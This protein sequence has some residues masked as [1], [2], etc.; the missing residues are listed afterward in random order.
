MKRLLIAALLLVATSASAQ[1]SETVNVEVIQVP[2]YV[3]GPDGAPI[4]GLKRNQFELYIDGY[5]KPFDYFDAV[6]VTAPTDEPRSQK[7]R[8]LYLLLFDLSC[9]QTDCAGLPGRVARAQRAAGKAIARSQLDTDLFA[10]ATYRTNHGVQFATPFLRD[11][12]AIQRAVNTLSSSSAADPLGLAISNAERLVW[13]KNTAVDNTEQAEIAM[14]TRNDEISR[15]IASI[16][17]G[18]VANQDNVREPLK[19]VI[20]DEFTE[21]AR[22]AGRLAKLEGQKHVI[23]FSQGFDANTVL[24]DAQ[25]D[26][27]GLKERWGPDGRRMTYMRKMFEAFQAAGVFLNTVDINGLRLDPKG[28]P[29]D[30]LQMLAS[31]T[32]GEFVKNRN[33][34]SVAVTDLTKRQEVAYLLGFDRRNLATGQIEIKVRGIPRGSRVSYRRGF[35]I[36]ADPSSIDSLQL[37]DIIVNDTPQTGVTMSI[38]VKGPAIFVGVARSELLPQINDREPWIET[39]LYV[40]DKDNN[41]VVSRQKRIEMT[42]ALREEKGPIVIGQKLDLPKGE[43][44]AKAITRIGGTAS[45]GF[46]RAEFTVE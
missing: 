41:A 22:V 20:E 5:P 33:D 43:Y 1:I 35:G 38:A 37:A 12:V 14:A 27:S 16:L 9:S 10:V 39:I 19:R 15:E 36:Q 29:V 13:N 3:I 2:V 7:E 8:R 45:V 34:I 46:A 26:Y 4:R 32:G 28:P 44:V 18:G 40:F 17:I 30:S 42:P 24:G 6:D 25:P 23:L 21:F 31:N 11:R